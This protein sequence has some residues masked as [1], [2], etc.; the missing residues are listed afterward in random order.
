LVHVHP[1]NALIE[2]GQLL[3]AHGYRFTPVTPAT[4]ARVNARPENALADGLDGV[5]GWSRKFHP[6]LLPRRMLDLLDRADALE[7]EGNALRSRVRFASLDGMLF[8]HSAFPTVAPDSVFFGPDTYRFAAALGRI[9]CADGARVAD[10][11]AGSGAGGL[12]LLRRA[13]GR[14]AVVLGDINPRALR[15]AAVNAA[16]NGCG[17]A[18]IVHSDVLS[19]I[20]GM[21]EL[22][23]ANPPYMID[24]GGPAYRDG[25]PGGIALSRRIVAEALPRLAAGGTL[26]LYTGTPIRRGRDALRDALDAAVDADRF[27]LDY[28]EIDPDVFGEELDAPAYAAADRIAAVLLT[29]RRRVDA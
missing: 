27:D 5:F 21:F 20:D 24:P 3:L 9:A 1:D 15:Y 18:E 10:V 8:V 11:G 6:G 14:V 7:P 12:S 19:G 29:V 22:I 25:G 2:L 17:G 23:V 16:L 13:Q 4:H 28:R 26:A